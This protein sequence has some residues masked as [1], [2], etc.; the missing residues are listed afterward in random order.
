[1][2]AMRFGTFPR[3]AEF[4]DL[5]IMIRMVSQPCLMASGSWGLGFAAELELPLWTRVTPSPSSKRPSEVRP[6]RYVMYLPEQ[7]TGSGYLS[8][9]TSCGRNLVNG[10]GTWM[11]SA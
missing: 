11:S 3:T 5:S 10:E 4:D 7:S 6:F 1:M 8:A 2:K 9:S